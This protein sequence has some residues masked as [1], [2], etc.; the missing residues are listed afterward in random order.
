[1]SIEDITP[2]VA[3]QR[4]HLTEGFTNLQT[5]AEQ[6]Y[7]PASETAQKAVGIDS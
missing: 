6:L 1:V 7:M 4:A 3:E 5:P 2:F